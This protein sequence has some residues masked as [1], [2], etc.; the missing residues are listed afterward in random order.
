MADSL[1]T[2][3]WF[4]HFNCMFL[5]CNRTIWSQL[6]LHRVLKVFSLVKRLV[7]PSPLLSVQV[8]AGPG[9]SSSAVSAVSSSETPGSSTSWRPSVSSDSTGG[10]NSPLSPACVF[11]Q[12]RVSISGVLHFVYSP[13]PVQR[14]Y[15][16]DHRA[17]PVPVLHSGPVQ[18]PAAAQPGTPA[19]S[20]HH[21]SCWEV[22]FLWIISHG[23][24]QISQAYLVKVKT[25]IPT[26]Y[27]NNR[28][29]RSTTHLT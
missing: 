8:S 18:P 7:C 22:V 3:H 6:R 5:K 9:V 24:I 12:I 10:E 17:V 23:N 4:Y 15:D 27:Q 20:L 28:T 1:L 16:P 25:R 21:V 26:R 14:W 19:W 29:W 2:V 11:Y 13:R